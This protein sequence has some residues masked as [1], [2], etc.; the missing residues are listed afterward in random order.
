MSNDALGIFLMNLGSMMI[1]LGLF[2]MF[3]V[4]ILYFFLERFDKS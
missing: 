2:L 4:V 1:D 3:I